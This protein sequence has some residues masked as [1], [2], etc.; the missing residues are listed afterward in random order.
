MEALRE[1]L[2]AGEHALA[3]HRLFQLAGTTTDYATFAALVRIRARLLA[4]ASRPSSP[5]AI[6]VSLLGGASTE[7]LEAPL[8]LALDA[9]G[10]EPTIQ[11][12]HYNAVASE[13]LDAASATAAFR[14]DVAIV[15]TKPDNMPAWPEVGA[16]AA[17]V[18]ALAAESADFWLGLCARLR[19][20]AGC[21]IVLDNFHPLPTRPLGNLAARTPWDANNFLRRVNLALGDRAP[22]Y[23]HIHDVEALSALHGLRRWIDSRY[24]FHAKQ[25]V[26]FACLVP[27]VKSVARVIGA[28]FGASAKCLVLDLDNTLWGGVVGD[29]GPEGIR[30]GEGDA[31]GEAFKAFQRYLLSLKQRGVMLAV[32]SKNDEAQALRPFTER[33]DMVLRRDDFV[34]FRANWNGKPENIAAIAAELNIGLGSIVF[35]DDNPFEREHVRQSLP[36]VNVLELSEDPADFALLLDD[37]G[38]F[39]ATAISAEDRQRTQQ[40]RANAERVRVLES[41]AD[42]TAY[43]RTLD[44]KAVIGPFDALHL[45]RITQLINKSNQFNLTTLRMTRSQVEELMHDGDALTACVRLT[46]RF[47]DNGL[48]SVLAA[49]AAGSGYVIDLWLMSCRVLRRGVEQLL[50]NYLVRAAAHRGADHLIGLYRPTPRN[51][52]VERHYESL[53]FDCIAREDD[54]ST[55]WRLDLRSYHPFDVT[56][57]LEEKIHERRGDLERAHGGVS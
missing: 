13:M 35:V 48:I 15:V 52:L 42:Y 6:R 5:R 14:P 1:L 22:E 3:W 39:E 18:T 38:L 45:D 2:R 56:I 21:D 10:L 25:P 51:G 19:E 33:S 49:H 17:R 40:Y 44:Q 9:L 54:G 24:W 43:L 20:H 31:V 34:A 11:R 55:R 37:A 46:D 50:C 36:E 53:G 28:V 8:A 16:D 57:E 41:A 23:V 26:S 7:L 47:G 12:A 30:I 32:C 29:D 4:T 27:Y